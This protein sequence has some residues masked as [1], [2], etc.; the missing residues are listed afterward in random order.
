MN[1]LLNH[2]MSTPFIYNCL[3]V[4]EFIQFMYYSIH[5]NMQFAFDYETFNYFRQF[6]SYIQVSFV[7]LLILLV[8]LYFGERLRNFICFNS[9]YYFCYSDCHVCFTNYPCYRN[10]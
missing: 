2:Q 4:L 3:I 5:P 7:C 10:Y 1:E 8:K 9:N 6:I